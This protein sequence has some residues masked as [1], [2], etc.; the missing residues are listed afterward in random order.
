MSLQN[1]LLDYEQEIE[2][3][4]EEITKALPQLK[5]EHD[6][7]A[8][9]TWIEGRITRARNV[10]RSIR[11]EVREFDKDDQE[12]IGRKHKCYKDNIDRLQERLKE[13]E[14]HWNQKMKPVD[15]AY[16]APKGVDD[17][18]TDQIMQKAIEIQDGDISR[19]DRVNALLRTDQE[20]A[21]ETLEALQRQTEQ[22]NEVALQMNEMES[23]LKKA[24]KQMGSFVRKVGTDKIFIILIICLMLLVIIAISI[25]FVFPEAKLE[26][27]FTT[28]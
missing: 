14:Q 16:L 20:I 9:I 8:K 18:T 5:K 1:E 4:I 25:K 17:M 27:V 2:A 10:L 22:M 3:L 15:K 26:D 24:R 21:T 23:N 28:K 11:I 13:E 7:L 12:I 19:I 6:K